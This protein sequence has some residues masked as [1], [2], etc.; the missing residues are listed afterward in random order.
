MFDGS[1]E[2]FEK[3]DRPDTADIIP[4]TTDRKILVLEQKQPDDRRSFWCFPGGVINRNEEPRTAARRE[5]LEET[6]YEAGALELWDTFMPLARIDWTIHTYIARHCK[7][8]RLQHLDAGERIKVHAVTWPQLMT[9]IDK[10]D[11][12]NIHI[13]LHLLRAA[14]V[15][16]KLAALRHRLLGA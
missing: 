6:G 10:P 7:K 16:K 12:R 4:I 9:I 5:L 13:A 15:Q 11:F 8:T 2:T 1:F 3:L 14:R